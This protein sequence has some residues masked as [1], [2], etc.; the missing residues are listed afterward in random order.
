[1]TAV[2]TEAKDAAPQGSRVLRTNLTGGAGLGLGVVV[3]WFSVLVLLPLSA[4]V[5]VAVNGGWDG[6]VATLTNP[7]TA[8]AL[9]LTVLTSLG[10][11]VLN[12]VM[13]TLIAWVL[14]R[15]RF[16]G[17][18]LLEVVIDVPFALP[19]IVAGLV[20]LAL[21]G[22]SS[23]VGINVAN[24][25]AAVFLAF[26]FVTLPFV[27]RSVQPVLEQ[28][29]REAEQAA[30]SLGASAGVTFRR[31]VL[32]A[33]IPAI[34]AGGALSFARGVSEYG[35]L[36][37]LSGNLALRTEVTSV[38]MLT[39]VENGSLASASVV[40]TVLLFVALVVLVAIDLLQRWLVRRG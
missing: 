40:A 17:S 12:V 35:S 14:V 38:R 19:T 10:V 25:R 15:E 27:V 22:P 13:G 31:I 6:F 32:P 28:L 23:P 1:M 5:A 34:A 29:D 36:V 16:R 3:L 4:V 30:H 9:E 7:Q 11:A 24:T 18:R 37:L 20:L 2:L 33:L 39:Y 21:Y 8:A 26:A